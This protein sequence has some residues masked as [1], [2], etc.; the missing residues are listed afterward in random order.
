VGEFPQG[1]QLAGFDAVCDGR[2]QWTPSRISSARTVALRPGARTLRSRHSVRVQIAGNRV[3]GLA[4]RALP[5][6]AGHHV[7]TTRATTSSGVDLGLPSVTPFSLL[8][9]SASRVRILMKSRSS[10]ANT[11][12]MCAMALPIGVRESIPSSVTI[13]RQPCS[14][15][16][17]MSRAKSSVQRLGCACPTTLI[18]RGAAL[19]SAEQGQAVTVPS[20]AAG[21]LAST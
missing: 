13:S 5:H 20:S 14:S 8:T 18:W 2:N 16:R 7:R 19:Q 17:R 10:S 11:T 3:C 12:A 21:T 6:N 1:P 4:L 9:C 15:D